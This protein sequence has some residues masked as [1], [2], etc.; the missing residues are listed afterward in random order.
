MVRISFKFGEV[1]YIPPPL[2]GLKYSG[3]IR[4]RFTIYAY[5]TMFLSCFKIGIENVRVWENELC[6]SYP[7]KTKK[8]HRI[9]F[10]HTKTKS[11]TR[12]WNQ[13]KCIG[14]YFIKYSFLCPFANRF[15]TYNNAKHRD[16]FSGF[17]FGTIC[18]ELF[19]R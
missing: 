5:Q 17:S 4:K 1:K 10:I 3:S 2:N 15:S 11:R 14:W 6:E 13:L 9:V 12:S 7:C 18:F 16:G 19:L 8:I